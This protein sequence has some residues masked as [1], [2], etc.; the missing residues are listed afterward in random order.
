MKTSSLSPLL[1]LSLYTFACGDDEATLPDAQVDS[2]ADADHDSGADGGP[3]VGPDASPVDTGLPRIEIVAGSSGGAGNLDGPATAAR[4]SGPAAVAASGDGTLY[5]ADASNY[6]IR[7]ISPDG[8]VTTLAGKA[9][10]PG[11]EDG[12]GEAA[13]FSLPVAIAIAPDGSLIVSDTFAGTL[14]RVSLGGEVTTYAGEADELGHVDGSLEEARFRGPEGLAFDANGKLYVADRESSTIRRITPEGQVETF[15]GA[16]QVLGSADGPRLLARLNGPFAVAVHAD[17]SL[18]IADSGNNTIRRVSPVGVVSTWAGT[19]GRDQ[20]T[21][22]GVGPAA[23]FGRPRGLVFEPNGDLLVADT[24]NDRLRRVSTSSVVTTVTGTSGAGSTDGPLAVAQLSFPS[25]IALIQE[26]G[27][28]VLYLA[29]TGGS[30]IR[31]IA[32]GTVSTHAGRAVELV[33]VDGPAAAARFFLPNGMWISGDDEIL[34]ADRENNALRRL[35]DDGSVSTLAGRPD[36]PGEVDGPLAEARFNR[37]TAIETD[38]EGGFFVADSGSSLIRHVTRDG[39]VSTFAGGPAGRGQTFV[40]GPRLDARF[41]GP[42]QMARDSAGRLYVVDLGNHAVRRIGTD[43]EVETIVGDGLPGYANGSGTESR[44]S[45]PE[46]IL[47]IDDETFI[48]GDTGNNVLR[49]VILGAEGATV[50]LLAGLEPIEEQP[51]R[52]SADGALGT[53]GFSAPRGLI[54]DGPD[55]LLVA[56]SH[57]NLLRRVSIADGSVTTIAGTRGS[58][59]LREGE[60][61][62]TLFEPQSLLRTP[63]GILITHL[64][65]VVRIRGL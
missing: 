64:G 30:T 49:K 57:N 41:Q 8:S 58:F 24:F 7:K 29:D 47:L 56:D 22:D 42:A 50:S 34:I 18:A 44:L 53:A 51:R 14:R 6:T 1:A 63:E 26:A 16:D 48:I 61:P 59:G 23:R 15:V 9:G 10:E 17:G 28:L 40:D 55:H 11:T 32:E 21:D 35:A 5:V 31:R 45:A 2:G 43:G 33:H 38:G 3:D 4:F 60:L 39:D 20:A 62:G 25:D 52:G 19:P 54:R 13:R 46:S 37:P 65:G 12:T 36:E 27:A